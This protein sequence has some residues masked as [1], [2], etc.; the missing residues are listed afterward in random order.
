MSKTI[1]IADTSCLI[2]LKNVGKLDLLKD[3]YTSI[4]ITPEVEREF[5]ED[6]PSW[7][8]VEG[9]K[10]NQKLSIL[11][12]ELDE[13]EASA[14]VLA[15]EYENSLLIID[16]KKGRNTAKRLGLQII[17][18]LGIVL[19]AKEKG[20]IEVVKPLL[21]ELEE[22]GFRIGRDLKDKILKKVKE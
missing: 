16:E 2:V 6:L 4:S 10:D 9:V 21:E 3:L 7:I 1:I 13:G 11:R 22:V 19:R 18:T 12:L 8:K 14:I 15:L 5:G 20:I 17:G